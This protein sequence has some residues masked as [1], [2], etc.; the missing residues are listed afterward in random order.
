MMAEKTRLFQDHRAV[1]LIMS[2]SSPSTRKRIGRGVRIFDPGV[3]DREK[4][5]A[6]L[7][8]TFAKSTW[9]P[10]IK[11]H[12]L[13]FDNKIL[14]ESSPLD[15]VWG[16]ADDPRVNNPCQWRGKLSSVRHFLP[17]A[18]LFATVRPGRRT[19]PPL[20]GFAPA[21][22]LQEPRNLVRAAAGPLTAAS[23]RN[24]SPWRFRP[25]SRARWPT[26]SREVLEI[27]SG[28]G[29]DLAMSEHGPCF[30]GGTVT[31][32]DVSFTMKIAYI[33]RATLDS[34]RHWTPLNLG[35][36]SIVWASKRLRGY[37]GE[38]SSAHPPATRH[39]RALT[40][41]GPSMH[42]SS[43]SLC[44]SPRS[45]AH[46]STAKAAPTASP[47]FL[48]RL[49]E[50][51]TEYD[52]S[53]LI[54]FNLV[55]LTSPN[56]V[57][58]SGIY[59]LRTGELRDPSSPNPGVGLGGLVPRTESTALGGLVPHTKSTASGGLVPLAESTV[60][61]GPVP[62]TEHTALGGLPL[63][64]TAFRDF[65]THEPRI[66]I[67]GLSAPPGRFVA[68]V[69]A[70]VATTEGC[71]GRGSISPAADTVFASVFAIPIEGGTGSA[72][73]LAAATPIAQPTPLFRSSTQETGSAATT[74]STVSISALL[75]APAPPPSTT[76]RR[77]A[78]A[79][80]NA[81]PLKN[82]DSGPAGPLDYLS[83]EVRALFAC[84]LEARAA[85]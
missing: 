74:G 67:D 6:V 28:V 63:T 15:P 34:E 11:N 30:T 81:P 29:P 5:N 22:R 66:R 45:I 8:G 77:T 7:S 33:S 39:R 32:D 43:G 59:L 18:K 20:V 4:Q 68:H 37:C 57:G 1:G 55:G 21:L 13:S 56:L 23:V 41:W 65:C 85:R 35:P 26:K 80:G 82:M 19:R 51:P 3:G 9:N 49:P 31:L 25:I 72:E 53:S 40:K 58:D 64:S 14:A 52:R 69:S 71:T 17:F 42:E 12:L 48:A 50:P 2:S 38:Q 10:A 76:R 27:A 75:G 83:Y 62:R 60:L 44:S 36:G 47:T 16:I 46:S 24:A 84:R 79:T 78:T 70:S 61:G 73:A 54:S